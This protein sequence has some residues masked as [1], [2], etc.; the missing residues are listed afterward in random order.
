MLSE[1][2]TEIVQSDKDKIVVLAAAAAGK[3]RVLTERVRNLLSRTSPKGIVVIT[4]TNMAANELKERLGSDYHS[5]M[6]V[7]TIHGYANRLLTQGGIS[8]KEVLDEEKFDKLFVMIKK[9]LSCVQKVEYLLLDEAQ[10]TGE[11]EHY[12]LFD[13]V[14]PQK[15]FIVGDL[16]QCQPAGTKILLRGGE[17]KKIEEVQT[18]DDV[19]YYDHT[20]G[21]CS[22]LKA[23]AYNAIHK[24]VEQVSKRKLENEE[25]ITIQ[26]ENGLISKYT[27]NHRTFASINSETE[28]QH[29]VYLM[30]DDADRFRIGKTLL[31]GTKTKNGDLWKNKM[32]AEGCNK[33]WLLE[34]F[35]TDKEAKV[36]EQKISYLYQIPQ[37]CWQVNRVAWTKEDVEYIYEGLNTH[38]N[39]ER[40]L[41][42]HHRNILYPIIDL[43]VPWSA[44]QHF[45]SN[46]ASQ[47]Y[48]CNL[49]K[50]IMRCVCYGSKEQAHS[51]KHFEKIVKLE[52]K[53]SNEYVY[54]LKV[55]GETYIADG[56]ATH[57]SIYGFKG[58]EPDLLKKLSKKKDVTV[59]SLNENYR[60][61]SKIL[62]YASNFLTKISM[63]DDSVAMKP[64]GGTVLE[65]FEFTKV[66]GTLIK[67]EYK[68]WALLTRTNAQIQELINVL[69]FYN[70]PYDT[71]RQGDLSRDE[72]NTK[73]NEDTVKVLTIHSSKGLE[74]DN[75]GVYGAVFYSE[76]EYR[77]NYVAATRARKTLIWSKTASKRKSRNQKKPERSFGW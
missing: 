44:S 59:Y 23:T 51:N 5:D 61:G 52:T 69:N 4:F 6:Y 42:D 1:L 75:V 45:A 33:I 12:F 39:A 14:K 13:M 55:E 21:R 47:L 32:L 18:G 72:L 24:K 68:N 54:S 29:I 27:Q 64:D 73:M 58:A 40:C 71:F 34:A 49:M 70:I 66:I 16:R 36:F 28:Y 60:N 57:N 19:V 53:I 17:E 15:F 48:A 3:T 50:E 35:K 41:A 46:A 74:W 37:T 8:T 76:E 31:R 65:T 38:N 9:N 56:I 7:G 77:V 63:G 67:G 22:S 30:C 43:T 20:K 62:N 11:M 26:S 10:D 25:I 2:Q